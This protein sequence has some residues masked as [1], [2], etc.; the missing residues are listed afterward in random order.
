[1]E[2]SSGI[3]N[4]LFFCLRVGLSLFSE[5]VE[6]AYTRTRAKVILARVDATIPAWRSL[7]NGDIPRSCMLALGI[8]NTNVLAHLTS[9]TEH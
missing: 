3:K 7:V 4:A 5:P 9:C 1:M 2:L 8:A 6:W